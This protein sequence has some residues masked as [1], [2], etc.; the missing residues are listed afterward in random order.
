MK[1]KA[2]PQVMLNAILGQEAVKR[3]AQE[4]GLAAN[5]LA[6]ALAAYQAGITSEDD[7]RET[8]DIAAAA[9]GALIRALDAYAA[10]IR[11]PLVTE[12]AE[13]QTK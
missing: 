12:V 4:F 6:K 1:F 11:E 5:N 2:Q 13:A 8:A 10:G 3:S 9:Q 7:V